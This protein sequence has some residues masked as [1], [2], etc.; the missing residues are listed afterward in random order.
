MATLFNKLLEEGVSPACWGS[1][2]IK[3]I[4]KTGDPSDPGNFRL[5]AL[6]LVVGKVFHKI[7]S[8]RLK[9]YLQKN[10]VIDTSVQKGFITGLPGVF[11]HV[12]SLSAILQDANSAKRPLMITFLNLKN[13]FGSVPHQLIFDM[14]NAVKV[15]PR[16]QSYIESLYSQFVIQARIGRPLRFLFT[17]GV[18]S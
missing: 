3:L 17:G 5:I 9:E 18:S 8:F 7:I 2:R 1:A 11:E 12:Y 16:I 6:T 4:Y 15:L 14:L 10:N 13:A